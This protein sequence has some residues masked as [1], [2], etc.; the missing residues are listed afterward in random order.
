MK[1][2]IVT[3]YKG[4]QKTIVRLENQMLC[5]IPF[6]KLQKTWAVFWGDAIFMLFSVG[7]ADLEVRVLS[8]E[9]KNQVVKC[10]W[11][12]FFNRMEYVSAW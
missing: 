2:G 10:L 11:W 5:A 8:D 9:I 3:V 12:S 7:P 1:A 6:G 4:K